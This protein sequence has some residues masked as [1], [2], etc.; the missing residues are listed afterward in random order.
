MDLSLKAKDLEEMGKTG[1]LDQA[2]ESLTEV[3]AEYAKVRSAL[4]MIQQNG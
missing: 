2:G 3:E 1:N 4:E